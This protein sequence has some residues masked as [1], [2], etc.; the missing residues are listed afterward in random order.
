ML[1]KPHAPAIRAYPT[2]LLR[3][4][5]DR[6]L[7][8]YD[9]MLADPA[10]LSSGELCTPDSRFLWTMRVAVPSEQWRGLASFDAEEIPHHRWHYLTYEGALSDSRG[11]V[12]RVDEGRF[13][14]LRWT[15]TLREFE[16]T[17]RECR[18][19]IRLELTSAPMWHATWIDT[20]K[21]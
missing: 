18:G 2:V 19:S 4:D 7:P 20:R 15:E 16:L 8:H 12:T 14:V 10:L 21:A 3:H 11:R 9:W 17:F 13:V 1:T 5:A 6:E